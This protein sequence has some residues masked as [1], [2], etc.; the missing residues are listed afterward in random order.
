MISIR[1]LT[2][3]YGK[4]K[5]L[6]EVDLEIAPGRITGIAGPNGSGK[7]T[8]IKCIV[9]L[10][11]PESGK[12]QIDGELA[13]SMG[14]FRYKIGYMA[15]NPN[16]PANLSLR[17]SMDMLTHL[18]RRPAVA[19]D[20]VIESFGLSEILNKPFASLSGGTRQKVAA[21]A[22]FMFD[23]PVIILD[24]PTAGLDPL[25]SIA[26]KEFTRRKAMAGKTIIFVSHFLTEIEQLASDIVF[27][28]ERKIL[29]SGAVNAL[30]ARECKDSLESAMI[31][32]F[33]EP[34]R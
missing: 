8:L 26:F 16:F 22:A 20:E 18:R 23:A 29:Y 1:D 15:Q 5:V 10:T 11:I 24:E 27:L 31:N 2:K 33:K 21:A 6:S 32:L 7:T 28:N 30:K 25:A 4:Q 3:S 34:A 12:I 9:G 14:E 19:R 13:D 17:E